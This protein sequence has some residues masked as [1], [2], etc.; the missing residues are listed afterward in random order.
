FEPGLHHYAVRDDIEIPTKEVPDF[1]LRF[2][3]DHLDD[4]TFHPLRLTAKLFQHFVEMLAIIRVCCSVEFG[5][6]HSNEC[7]YLRKL[8]LPSGLN[9]FEHPRAGDLIDADHHRLSSLPAS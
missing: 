7:L 9:A 3:N 8:R 5:V 4:R 1:I 2:A 6:P